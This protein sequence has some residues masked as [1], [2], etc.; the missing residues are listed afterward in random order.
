MTNAIEISNLCKTFK[1]YDN[2]MQ[3]ALDW[4]GYYKLRFWKREPKFL[5]KEALNNINLDIKAGERY[6]LV[7]RNGAGKTT[8][9]KA[10]AGLSD[11]TSGKIKLNGKVQMLMH[12]GAS[13]HPEFTGRQNVEYSLLY[14]GLRGSDLQRA[15]DDVVDFA[16]LGDFMDQPLKNYSLGMA[17]RLQFAAATSIKPEILMIDEVL[18]AGDAYF[19][20]K[21]AERMKNLTNT[22]CTLLL[23]SHAKSQILE[24]CRQGIWLDQGKIKRTGPIQDVMKDY[25]TDMLSRINNKTDDSAITLGIFP[26][27]ESMKR[28]LYI[29]G[30]KAHY[31]GLEWKNSEMPQVLEEGRQGNHDAQIT[32]VETLSKHTPTN[33]IDTGDDFEIRVS[34]KG[35]NPLKLLSLQLSAFNH[36][37]EIV[38]VTHSPQFEIAENLV[39]KSHKMQ[40]FNL[41]HRDYL[42]TICLLHNMKPIQ[43]LCGPYVGVNETN[44]SDPPLLHYPAKW[45]QNNNDTPSF[46]RITGTQ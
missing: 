25:E 2:H 39:V 35:S 21:S 34:V 19:S 29:Q 12:I 24:F 45:Y 16:E 41:G 14:Q 10:L 8:L 31:D 13:F 22:G 42:Y 27:P 9:L 43:V 5:I 17:S 38:G 7:G 44:D 26:T 15:Y 20:A 23:V 1:M 40:P 33:R 37:G 46:S 36:Q 18:G 3:M 32:S 4:C 11:Y 6:G 28:P 30:I